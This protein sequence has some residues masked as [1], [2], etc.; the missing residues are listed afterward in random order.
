MPN[1]AQILKKLQDYENTFFSYTS[2]HTKRAYITD[3]E[4]FLAF[5]SQYH[6]RL[7]DM[8]LL[9]NLGIKDVRAWLMAR[10]KTHSI[11]S[12]VRAFSAVKSFFSYLAKNNFIKTSPFFVMRPPRLKKLL[13]KA[14][15]IE[16]TFDI[17]DNI[18]SNAKYPWVG[19]RDKA[20]FMLIY[21]VGLRIQE[22]LDLNQNILKAPS[23]LVQGKGNKTRY[24]PLLDSVKDQLSLYLKHCPHKLDDAAPLFYGV[25][26]MRLT[27][28]VAQKT[29]RCYKQFSRLPDHATPHAL[30]HSC[31]TH[32]I[33]QTDD[34]RTVSELLGHA[35]LSTTQIY[36]HICQEKLRD[37]YQMAHP[38]ASKK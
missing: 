35:S 22:A 18:D 30:R 16:Q 26:G 27:Q 19:Y 33:D 12:T 38:R 8:D 29:M 21:S 2:P 20:L 36:T 10:Q 1:D 7:C 25:K 37:T 11:R 24:V 17:L 13:P 3:I 4:E 14:L 9:I 28:G 15:S 34:I 32:L 5:E 23:L 6:G 31:A